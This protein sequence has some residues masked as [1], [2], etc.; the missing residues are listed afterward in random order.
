MKLDNQL[1]DT[2]G[3]FVVGVK[4]SGAAAEG[5]LRRGGVIRQVDGVEISSLSDFESAYSEL[6]RLESNRALLTVTS[7]GSTR[8]VLLK[9]DEKDGGNDDE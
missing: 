2:L 8:F 7:G 5:G 4:R 9:L 6:I 3:V 1:D